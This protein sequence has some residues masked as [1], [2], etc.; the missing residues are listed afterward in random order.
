MS[1][2]SCRKKGGWLRNPGV[3]SLLFGSQQS[4]LWRSLASPSQTFDWISTEKNN[5][6]LPLDSIL[7][8]SDGRMKGEMGECIRSLSAIMS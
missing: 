7:Y 5:R 8:I 4:M 3:S 2:N 1:K 6:F